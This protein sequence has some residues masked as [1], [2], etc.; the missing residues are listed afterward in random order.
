MEDFMIMNDSKTFAISAE[1]PTGKRGG[2]TRGKDCEKLRPCIRVQPGET[3]TLADIEG[4]GR[5]QSIWAG[6]HL[7]HG[8]ILR[9]FWDGQTHPSVECP[10]SAFFGWAYDEDFADAKGDYVTLNSAMMMV[11]PAQGGNCYWPMPFRKKC[12]IT[13]ENR[14]SMPLDIYYMIMG[15]MGK[16]PDNIGYFHASYRQAHPVEKGK[17]YTVIDGIKGKGKFVGVTMSVGLNGHNTC[18]VEGETKMYID[19]DKYP[20]VNYTGTEDYFCGSFA[21]GN[22]NVLHKYQTYQGHYAGL[23]AVMGNNDRLYKGQE[24]FLLYRWHVKDAVSFNEDFV[25]KMDNLGW[26]GPRYDD[27]TTVAYWYQTLPS[28]PLAPLPSDSEMLMR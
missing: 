6:G 3:I 24:R 27:Y 12:L 28:A 22:D 1:N 20:S 18:W 17:S 16:Q 23:A 14:A 4:E 10:L 26:T 8:F 7:N 5:I 11:A 25:M 2:G 21:Y 9:I 19:G 15:E 13:L